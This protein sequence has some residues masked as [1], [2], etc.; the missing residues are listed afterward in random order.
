MHNL[1]PAGKEAKIDARL[2]ATQLTTQQ[3]HMVYKLIHTI[4]F[5]SGT[6]M[7]IHAS[8]RT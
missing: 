4:D 3:Q 8:S 1:L 6:S 5:N 7:F 2:S